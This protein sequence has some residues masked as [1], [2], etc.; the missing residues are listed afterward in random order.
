[1]V[2]ADDGVS[3]FTIVVILLIIV[4]VLMLFRGPGGRRI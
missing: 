4:A 3:L 2:L 1:M